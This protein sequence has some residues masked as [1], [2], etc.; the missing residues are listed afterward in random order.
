MHLGDFADMESLCSYDKGKKCFEGRRYRKDIECAQRGMRRLLAP[1]T[2]LNN[3]RRRDKKRL[4]RPA[5]HMLLGN[6]EDRIDRAIQQQ[7]ELDGAIGVSDLQYESFGWRVHPF[8]QAVTIDGVTY[9]HY[10]YNK[11]SGRPHPNA[12][13]MLAREHT[14][15][16]QG[17]VQ[18]LDYEIQ[19]TGAGQALHGLRVGAC[20]QHDEG[21][22]GPQG[23]HHWRGVVVKRNVRNGE[24]DPQFISLSSLRSEYRGKGNRRTRT[25][26]E[27]AHSSS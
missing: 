10:F 11:L 15:C 18:V 25:V 5:M 16:T 24:Y 4:Y 22:K 19:Y 8:L 13:L 12:R 9:S 7:P 17:H 26:Q 23:N 3:E 1:L 20:Y 2:R 21:Y 14:S 6:H 27:A